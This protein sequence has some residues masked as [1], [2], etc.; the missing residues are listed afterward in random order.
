M[1]TLAEG[2]T[3]YVSSTEFNNGVS[4][5]VDATAAKDG[6]VLTVNRGGSVGK[7]FYQAESFAATPVDVRILKPKFKMTKYTAIFLTVIIE[8][9]KYRFNYSRK[10]G[11]ACINNLSIKLPHGKDG[12]P[13]WA[14]MEKYI[15]AQ[16]YSAS[17]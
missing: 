17:L 12:K 10:M 9:E 1:N 11:T 13:D 4:A 14:F 15:R 6:H 16:P 5:Y 3:P 8:K 2:P 7:T